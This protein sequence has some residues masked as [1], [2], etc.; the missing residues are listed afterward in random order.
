MKIVLVEENHNFDK[1]CYCRRISVMSMKIVFVAKKRSC[2]GKSF[3]SR[4]II[5]VDENYIKWNKFV[6]GKNPKQNIAGISLTKTIIVDNAQPYKEENEKRIYGKFLNFRAVLFIL[7]TPTFFV[8]ELI[9]WIV[10]IICFF[11]HISA[12]YIYIHIQYIH[13]SL[14]YKVGS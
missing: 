3:W 1:K 13:S 5:L 2:R 14:Y 11:L 8:K 9:K 10:L 7:F 4:K 12:V 6:K